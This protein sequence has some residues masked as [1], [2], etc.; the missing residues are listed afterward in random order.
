MSKQKD[1]LYLDAILQ[2]PLQ[3]GFITVRFSGRVIKPVLAV[4]DEHAHGMKEECVRERTIG[5]IEPSALL[6]LCHSI[7][8]T[9]WRAARDILDTSNGTFHP[10]SSLTVLVLQPYISI[11]VLDEHW[12]HQH[13]PGIVN[14]PV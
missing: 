5:M 3:K 2:Q 1:E 12:F 6:G 8:L 14:D 7:P 4:R 10:M 13:S 11:A 9:E